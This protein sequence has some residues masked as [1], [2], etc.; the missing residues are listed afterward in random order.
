M[1]RQLREQNNLTLKEAAEY[2]QKDLSSLSRFELGT[3]PVRRGDLLALMDLYGLDDKTQR[4]TLLNLCG[5]V[6]QT[7]WW[8]KYTGADGDFWGS[9]IDFVWLESRAES[10]KAFSAL[11][12]PGLLQTPAYAR[13]IM[14]VVNDGASEEQKDRW[15]SLRIER[16]K[17]L[18]GERLLSHEVVFD[19]AALR[20][21]FGGPEVMAE[22]LGRLR[23]LAEDEQI[24]MRMIPFEAGGHLSP[25]G[26]FILLDLGDPFTTVAHV[27][28][29]GGGLYLERGDVDKLTDIFDGLQKMALSP[30]DSIAFV[31]D[32]ERNQK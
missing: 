30:G 32:L 26:A 19:E 13:A 31:A 27:E 23:A 8:H 14:D 20:R 24:R 2:L 17:I 18:N 1:L 15:V 11:V 16:Q 5:E 21:S 22:Q 6:W 28:S 3:F 9:T 12:V 4:E 25:E 7:G 29:P 10:I